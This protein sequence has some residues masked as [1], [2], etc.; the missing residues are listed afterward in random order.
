M[1]EF[2]ETASVVKKVKNLNL[3]G[4]KVVVVVKSWKIFTGIVYQD[5]PLDKPTIFMKICIFLNFS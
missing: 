3:E 5:E 4:S 2:R 1:L